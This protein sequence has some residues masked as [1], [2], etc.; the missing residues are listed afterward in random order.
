MS[1]NELVDAVLVLSVRSFSER[2]AHMQA[3]LSR[4]HIDFQFIFDFDADAIPAS[5]IERT[6][7]PSDLRLAHQ[8]LVL[9]HIRSWQLTVERGWSSVLVLEDDAVLTRG[10]ESGFA[11]VMREADALAGPYLIYLG[12]GDNRYL[13]GAKRSSRMLL[14]GGLLPAT[15]SLVFNCEAAERRL[16]YLRSHKI[17]RPADWLTREIDAAVGIPHYWLRSPIVEQG[18][19]NGLFESVLDDK[20][21]A[22]GRWYSWLR[23]RWN[24]FR[25]H[26]LGGRTVE[27]NRIPDGFS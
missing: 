17:T 18:S 12:C 24:K 27:S 23:Y 4:H 21:K 13:E 16:A 25:Q 14:P 2:I 5:L 1:V 3:E 11:H 8:S 7:A 6:F 20:R 10:F 15:E 19:M 26:V 9:K 22:R